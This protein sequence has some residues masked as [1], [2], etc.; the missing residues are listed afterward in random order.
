MWLD[1]DDG[2]PEWWRALGRVPALSVLDYQPTARGLSGR[3]RERH[4]RLA[5]ARYQR[6][7]WRDYVEEHDAAA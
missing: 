2:M 4:R 6:T 1:W 7:A 5:W 3:W